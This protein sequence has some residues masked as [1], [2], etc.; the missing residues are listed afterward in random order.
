[1]V[2]LSLRK[3]KYETESS[4]VLVYL[5]PEAFKHAVIVDDFTHSKTVRNVPPA[6]GFLR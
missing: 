4:S 5:S 2:K 6:E 1:M 3:K